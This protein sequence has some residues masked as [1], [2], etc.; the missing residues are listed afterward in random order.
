[1]TREEY[2][3]I[4]ESIPPLPGCYRYY[5]NQQKLLYVGK[6]KNLR[7]RVTSYFNSTGISYKTQK[8]VTLIHSIEVTI[9]DSEHDAFLL[10][11]SLIKHHQPKFNINLRDDKTYPYII[12]KKEAF[13]RVFFTRNRIKD[14]SEY[15][16]PFTGVWRVKE[17]MDIIKNN[18][19]LRTCSLNLSPANINKGKYKVCLEYHL[20]NCKGPCEGLQTPEDYADSIQQVRHILKG[21]TSEIIKSLKQEMQQYAAKMEFEKA[22]LLKLKIEGLQQYT[23]QSTVV[24]T[25]LDDLDIATII[26]EEEQ[27]YI[28][29]MMLHHGTVVYSKSM[30]IDKLKEEE[31]RSVLSLAVSRMRDTF[32][33]SSKE[34][35]V[36]I[37]IDVTDEQ[38]KI[39]IPKAGDKKKLLDLSFKNVQLHRDEERRKKSLLLTEKTAS[40]YLEVVEELQEVLHLQDLPLHIECFDNSNFQGAYP[41]AAMV[42]FKDGQPCKKEYRHFH[43]KTVKGINDFA[44]MSE[45]VYRRYKRLLDEKKSLPQL[46]IIDGGK[47][48]LHA[49]LESIEKLGLIGRMTVVGL[50]K[51]EESIFFPGDASPLQLPFDSP[52]HLLIRRIRDEVHRFGITFHRQIRSKGTIKNE[53]EAIP[54]IGEKIATQLLQEFRSVKQIKSLTERELTRV[55]GAKKAALVYAYFHTEE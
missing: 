6:A 39:T 35:I 47:G 24:S 46:V 31:E 9:T 23:A 1:M 53:L 48:Q 8:L 10:E 54:G 13:P 36:P 32:N 40:D 17:L 38:L 2:A 50:A 20:G 27:A 41:V 29:F 18:I 4:K 34:I 21:N 3:G 12:I 44:S 49:A 7:K 30:S 22:H 45:I 33:S 43:I 19:P 55:I 37:P 5:D 51:R 26:C 28:N 42:C 15:I 14:G 52:V 11:N 16:G 25:H